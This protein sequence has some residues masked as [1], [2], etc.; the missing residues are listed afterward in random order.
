[1]TSKRYSTTSERT[2]KTF[3]T[4]LGPDMVQKTTPGNP[5]STFEMVPRMPY[6][7]TS[8]SKPEI[9]TSPRWQSVCPPTFSIRRP[10]NRSVLPRLKTGPIPWILLLILSNVSTFFLAGSV[11]NADFV[12]C[13]HVLFP[14]YRRPF[15]YVH[16]SVMPLPFHYT[17]LELFTVTNYVM[18]VAIVSC[19]YCCWFYVNCL[20][21]STSFWFDR[22]HVLLTCFV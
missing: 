6:T 12:L 17:Q 1:M 8:Q 2:E 13:Y 15:Q 5:T 11:R 7:N 18:L 14:A 22:R 10:T 21:V 3:G 20:Y 9:A 4:S 19:F 16:V